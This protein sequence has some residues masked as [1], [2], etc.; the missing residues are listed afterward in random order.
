MIRNDAF[1]ACLDAIKRPT[2]KALRDRPINGS[3]LCLDS[4]SGAV[5]PLRDIIK[6][7]DC[8]RNL[9]SQCRFKL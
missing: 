6:Q 2:P 1:L 8:A 4:L 7:K 9:T 5:E 3:P